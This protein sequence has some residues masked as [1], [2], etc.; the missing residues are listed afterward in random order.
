MQD[1]GKTFEMRCFVMDGR[2]YAKH[3]EGVTFRSGKFT[4]R[5]N[6]RSS[7][8]NMN[9]SRPYNYAVNKGYRTINSNF[10]LTIKKFF[11]VYW[12]IDSTKEKDLQSSDSLHRMS[13][14][15]LITASLKVKIFFEVY[16]ELHKRRRSVAVFEIYVNEITSQ[17]I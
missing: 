12:I 17:K 9:D 1:N 15:G 4:Y 16:I 5:L 2:P 10:G 11:F 6:E 14:Y 13:W 7:K 8:R 3:M